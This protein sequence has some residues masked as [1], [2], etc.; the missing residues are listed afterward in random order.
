MSFLFIGYFLTPSKVRNVLLIID[1]E[2]IENEDELWK[3]SVFDMGS[4]GEHAISFCLSIL[5][6][7][8]LLLW[9]FNGSYGLA[10]IPILL[11][12]GKNSLLETKTE[13]IY[14]NVG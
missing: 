6:S 13:V 1:Y 5:I 2:N 7:I 12:K 8:G 14:Y 4:A 9:I 11:I 3:K 10:T